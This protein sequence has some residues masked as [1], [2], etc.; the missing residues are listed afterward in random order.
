MESSLKK[1]VAKDERMKISE[2]ALAVKRKKDLGFV[3]NAD[4]K[5]KMMALAD[6]NLTKGKWKFSGNSEVKKLTLFSLGGKPIKT[7]EFISWLEH[8]HG[9]SK[10][11]PQAYMNQLYENWSEEKINEAEEAKIIDENPDFKYL[12]GEYREGILLFEIM[13][14]EVWNK[15]SEDSVGQRK[16]Y[17]EHINNYSAGNRVEARI[18]YTTDKAFLEDIKKKIASGDTLKEADMK[19]LKSAQN[20]RN[21]E[22]GESKAIDKIN[23]IP[24]MQETE[25]EGTYYLVEI[26]KLIAPGPKTFE[27]ARAKVISDYQDSLEK[28]WVNLLKN[29]YRVVINTKAKKVVVEELTKL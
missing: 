13:E 18:F 21:Y 19:K 16:Y 7:S 15:A 1:R 5:S 22:K 20:F 14:K 24:G 27:E 25:I 12:L 23:W 4:S 28:N 26:R 10:L 29:K 11:A 17:R 9:S 8:Q 2:Q 3:E 6:S